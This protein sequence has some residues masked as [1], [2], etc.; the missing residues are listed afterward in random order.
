G[1]HGPG[2]RR[3]LVRPRR[4]RRRH[5]RGLSGLGD[6]APAGL[7][8]VNPRHRPWEEAVDFQIGLKPIA[9]EA[10]LEGGEA[11]PAARKDPLFATRRGLVWAEAV[12]SRPAQVEAL[13]L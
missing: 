2:P 10:W 8:A 1:E 5:R 4:R 11:D 9:P 7:G 6:D 12:G 3:Q 13:E